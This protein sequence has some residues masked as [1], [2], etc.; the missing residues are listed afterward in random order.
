MN[1]KLIITLAVLLTV[2]AMISATFFLK[3]KDKNEVTN[4]NTLM[5]SKQYLDQTII[6][7]NGDFVYT[8]VHEEINYDK[9]ENVLYY[10]NLLNVFLTSEISN[11]EA[12]QL[13]NEVDGD[14]VGKL[15]GS[16]NM[17]Q[18]KVDANNLKALEKRAKHLEQHELVKYASTS[19][20]LFISDLHS[21]YVVKNI[22]TIDEANPD[23][24]NWWAEAINAYSAW[25]YI[26]QHKDKFDEVKVAVFESGKLEDPDDGVATSIKDSV[27]IVPNL[28]IQN[29]TYEYKSHA[30]LVTETIVAKENP[31]TIRGVAQPVV[32]A[33]F[34][35]MGNIVQEEVEE[36][37]MANVSEAELISLI[38]TTVEDEK[39]KVINNS[40]GFVPMSKEKWKEENWLNKIFSSNYKRYFEAMKES[41]DHIS[42]QLMVALDEL[43][44]TE[45]VL[46]VQSA[47]NG[48]IRA[49][50]E[51][52]DEK[53]A[54]NAKYTGIFANINDSTF[55]EVE[56]KIEKD[57]ED[58]LDHIII[59]GGAMQTEGKQGYQSPSWASYGDAI[60]IAAPAE[61]LFIEKEGDE[62][63]Y[64]TSYAA[65]MVSGAAAL[66]WSYHSDI[67]AREGKQMLLHNA[68]DEVRDEKGGKTYSYPLLNMTSFLNES[69][70]NVSVYKTLMEELTVY[71]DLIELYRTAIKEQW[72]KERLI[73]N[74]IGPY[75]DHSEPML[76]DDYG[77]EFRDINGDGVSEFVLGSYREDGKAEVQE[78]YTI[79]NDQPARIFVNGLRTNIHIYRDG[80]ISESYGI[81]SMGYYQLNKDGTR[82]LIDGYHLND[83]GEYEHIVDSSPMT[84]KDIDEMVKKYNDIGIINHAFTPFVLDEAENEVSQQAENKELSDEEA[85]RIMEENYKRLEA[86]LLDIS[87]DHL[88]QKHH[89]ID[90]AQSIWES[91]VDTN[92]PFYEDM[93]NLLIS[94]VGNLVTDEGMESLINEKFS[95]YWQ[96]PAT[97]SLYGPKPHLEVIEKEDDSF[98]IKQTKEI[99]PQ[100]A[101]GKSIDIVY[102][103]KYVKQ[104]GSWK[105][106]GAEKQ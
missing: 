77:Y 53:T 26:D 3:N 9:E 90:E 44:K 84:E 54:L 40:W 20:P 4:V 38:K 43:L 30:Q 59:V 32:K 87:I 58:I 18:I 55:A 91:G 71:K 45:D 1:K 72:S 103:V 46:F 15:A 11:E 86:I 104:D 5:I 83:R 106:A 70:Y 51:E 97:I 39:V 12:E 10:E 19:T 34:I 31:K 27:E 101:G 29:R 102:I 6:H 28:E 14:I 25:Y 36:D 65:P 99:G 17:V 61:D 63:T 94:K 105:F 93:Y 74:E 48:Y 23:G 37:L 21:D 66:I 33:R 41:N 7:D 2:I 78:I 57:V 73:K 76:F 88:Y 52:R 60:D 82:E 79:Q 56:D 80:T 98:I 16:L 96:P 89:T 47:G 68:T 49:K 8:P 64:G 81:R 67:N 13:A 95:M 42:K 85:K 50:G 62:P 24:N 22:D 92:S 35:S 69:P 100:E 75:Y